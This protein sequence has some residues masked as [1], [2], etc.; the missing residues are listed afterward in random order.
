MNKN[1]LWIPVEKRQP[2]KLGVYFLTVGGGYKAL[3]GF[4]PESKEWT[5]FNTGT[6]KFEV[7]AWLDVE[8]YCKHPMNKVEQD[9]P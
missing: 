4:N 3:G 6:V 7:N 9:K 1:D 5:V 8:T 2:E